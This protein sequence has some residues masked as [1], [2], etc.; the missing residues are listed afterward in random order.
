MGSTC[1]LPFLVGAFAFDGLLTLVGFFIDLILG[2]TP[3]FFAIFSQ[4]CMSHQ[5]RGTGAEKLFREGVSGAK[6]DRSELALALRAV[7]EA[8]CL[9]RGSTS[10]RAR[11]AIFSIRSTR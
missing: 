2:F 11:R 6:A 5:L 9:S 7:G 8:T 3:V 1:L 10:W 4:I